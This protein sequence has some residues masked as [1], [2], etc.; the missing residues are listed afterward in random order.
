MSATPTPWTAQSDRLGHIVRARGR[1]VAECGL[2]DDAALIAKAVN[3]HA[4]LVAAL[5]RCA[6]ELE[7]HDAC[8]ACADAVEKANA[9]LEKAR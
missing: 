1:V 3:C 7:C 4:E 8:N 9:I 2:A 6:A 5:G